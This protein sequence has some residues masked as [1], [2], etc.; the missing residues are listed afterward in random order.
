VL[1]NWDVGEDLIVISTLRE[2]L[3]FLPAGDDTNVRIGQVGT[4]VD[5]V[6]VDHMVPEV[7]AM[8]LAFENDPFSSMLLAF[9]DD[10]FSLL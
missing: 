8:T 7:R 1:V 3:Q 9:Q 4:E 6:V 10:P 2:P 5:F